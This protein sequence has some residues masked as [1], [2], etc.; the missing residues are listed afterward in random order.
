MRK[1]NI[2][3]G[4]IL[5]VVM[6]F[7]SC[8][9]EDEMM[10]QNEN[11]ENPYNIFGEWHNEGLDFIE[12]QLNQTRS[13]Y[14]SVP[15]N[16]IVA[17]TN[18]CSIYLINKIEQTENRKL[19]ATEINTLNTSIEKTK[20]Y[21]LKLDSIYLDDQNKIISEIYKDFKIKPFIQTYLN[22]II[23]IVNNSDDKETVNAALSNLENKIVPGPLFSPSDI[24]YLFSVISIARS[25]YNYW[26]ER[27]NNEPQTR[28]SY[29]NF[30]KRICIADVGGAIA[31]G[32]QGAWGGG[33]TGLVFGPG[34]LVLT[35]AGSA[36]AG[37]LWSSGMTAASGGFF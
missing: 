14:E 15:Q 20:D 4:C 8:N 19:T 10:S 28:F 1:M 5:L 18:Q 36:V 34:G 16:K 6:T 25:S 21:L 24:E 17:V 11:F 12:K 31:G 27:L 22:K 23:A 3:M 35:I 32:I 26:Y 13:I 33:A 37:G 29:R 9:N 30:L 7:W 2:L